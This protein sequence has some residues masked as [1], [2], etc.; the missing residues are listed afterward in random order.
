[1]RLEAEVEET[2]N[3]QT[4]MS[5]KNLFLQTLMEQSVTILLQ[6]SKFQETYF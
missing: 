3:C 6:D 1:M 4:I 5:D 2:K